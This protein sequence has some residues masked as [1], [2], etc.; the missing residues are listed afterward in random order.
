MLYCAVGGWRGWVW[1]V[2]GDWKMRVMR[3]EEINGL[4]VQ[5]Q[6]G[7]YTWVCGQTKH[8]TGKNLT[9]THFFGRLVLLFCS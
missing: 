8:K 5:S 2:V 6:V 7:W 3:E 4:A 1:S 9:T